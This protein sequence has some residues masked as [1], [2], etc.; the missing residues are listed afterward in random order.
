MDN[1]HFDVMELGLF[2]YCQTPNLKIQGC[3]ALWSGST[4]N[5]I[6]VYDAIGVEFDYGVRV[7]VV[8]SGGSFHLYVD[9]SLIQ[10]FNGAITLYS[11]AT[12]TVSP[13]SGGGSSIQISNPT[14]VTSADSIRFDCYDLGGRGYIN[15]FYSPSI[16]NFNSTSGLC[17]T[18]DCNSA[19]DL[20]GADSNVYSLGSVVD[21]GH[22]WRIASVSSSLF[23]NIPGFSCS[24]SPVTPLPPTTPDEPTRRKAELC[25]A[26]IFAINQ[27]AYV[28][29]TTT[30]LTAF[31][32][33]NP[34]I[35]P[36]SDPYYENCVYDVALNDG[37]CHGVVVGTYNR[38]V[39]R[40]GCLDPTCSGHGEC[41]Y[42]FC[43]CEPGWEGTLC[44]SEK[45]NATCAIGTYQAAYDGNCSTCVRCGAGSFS[46]SLNSTSCTACPI[47]SYSSN[48]GSSQCTTCPVGKTTVSQGSNHSSYC[49]VPGGSV[50]LY[51][52]IFIY[53]IY[54]MCV[55]K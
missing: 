34:L 13:I 38:V 25:C 47:G 40:T 24:G 26:Y 41:L 5:P 12:V 15:V 52:F 42:G 21:W 9:D 27:T 43:Y 7:A 1:L 19:S 22:T 23:A 17:G 4:S 37:V 54:L 49:V 10:I 8:F 11:G 53:I 48:P 3:H 2:T 35:I 14:F 32:V 20:I 16:L 31:I 36:I 55:L 51:L 46:N 50:Y 39:N 28:S 30:N 29:V 44:Q 18:W 33:E 6:S 45:C